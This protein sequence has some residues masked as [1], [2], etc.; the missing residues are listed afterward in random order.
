LQSKIVM[1][2]H[3]SCRIHLPNDFFLWTFKCND[4]SSKPS[5]IY[6][7]IISCQKKFKLQFSLLNSKKIKLN[8]YS[9]HGVRSNYVLWYWTIIC[10]KIP[11][12]MMLLTLCLTLLYIIFMFVFLFIQSLWFKPFMNHS[13]YVGYEKVD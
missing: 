9:M 12:K 1:R 13:N 2:R 7:D 6:F 10:V 4:H 5:N 11:T 3:K 8:N